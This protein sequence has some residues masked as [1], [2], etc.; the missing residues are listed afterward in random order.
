MEEFA[1]V[2]DD[3]NLTGAC[4]DGRAL[5][6]GNFVVRVPA[7]AIPMQHAMLGGHP[8]L[9]AIQGEIAVMERGSG[10]AIGLAIIAP[11]RPVPMAH[12]GAAPGEQPN[13]S[14]R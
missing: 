14:I 4:R 10:A 3:P 11:A 6:W 7:L 1:G 9:L 5:L 8:D 13:G 12:R 2:V